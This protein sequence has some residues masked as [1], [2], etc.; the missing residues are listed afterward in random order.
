MAL[1]VSLDFF[2][3]PGGFD[4]I[5][6]T[7]RTVMLD[8]VREWRALTTSRDAF[9]RSSTTVCDD[10]V[11]RGNSA[12]QDPQSIDDGTFDRC[13][14]GVDGTSADAHSQ[15]LLPLQHS[16]RLNRG[17]APRSIRFPLL[18]GGGLIEA[19]GLAVLSVGGH[20][21]PRK[22]GRSSTALRSKS[23]LIFSG[24]RRVM[25]AL[26]G[27]RD[28]TMAGGAAAAERPFEIT[29]RCRLTGLR[30]EV[31]ACLRPLH[32]RSDAR[33]FSPRACRGLAWPAC[34]GPWST[35]TCAA[36]C[37]NAGSAIRF[38]PRLL[39]TRRALSFRPAAVHA[40]AGRMK[41][42]RSS[43]KS[44]T[45]AMRSLRRGR[46]SDVDDLNAQFRRWRDEVAHRRPHPEQRDQT[47]AQVFAQEQPRLLPLPAHPFETDVMR[48][49]VSGKTP[50]VRFDRNSYSIPH[51]HV[52]R[53]LSRCSRARPACACR[54][55]RRDRPPWRAATT[56]ARPSRSWRTS[57]ACSRPPARRIRRAGAIV[58]V[59]RSRRSPRYSSGSA[60][61]GES[62]R[63]PTVR[64]LGLLDDYGPAGARRRHRARRSSATPSAPARSRTCSKRAGGRRRQAP[65]IPMA[66]PDR[67][68][69]PRSRRSR[70]IL[71][72]PTMTSPD[73]IP[74]TLSDQLR[75]VGL[76]QTATD[77]N[78]LIA[79]ATQKR[80]S[81]VVLLERW[82]APNSTRGPG[83]ASNG[84]SRTRGSA[85][86][87]RWLIL[88]GLGRSRSIGPV[89]NAS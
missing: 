63:A 54:R 41:R 8:N 61:P 12:P 14:D 75:Q 22:S 28:H 30:V 66:L 31:K 21:K 44:N 84:G 65:P 20:L 19:L 82:S 83:N 24:H 11:N 55:R 86:S 13:L 71:W 48:P 32:R 45:C 57:R 10:Q 3:G 46:L 2:V 39:E 79:R 38:H 27:G 29:D 80:W 85:A 89:S 81:P 53:P 36:P 42:A 23:L 49:V 9:P 69:R 73:P 50:Y 35:T 43:A 78:D 88:S 18:K 56:R 64:L 70:P 59:W 15:I 33:E 5:P 34:H 7:S 72:S 67:P 68:G 77:L 26:G 76:T 62:L 6:S 4:Q 16:F 25:Q 87:S 52:R 40:R 60:A 37:S 51:T 58:C 1:R 74:T 47:V 17:W